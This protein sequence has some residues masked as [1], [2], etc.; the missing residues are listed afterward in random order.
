MGRYH[1]V[2]CDKCDGRGK[3][4]MTGEQILKTDMRGNKKGEPLLWWPDCKACNGKGCHIT[5]NPT[6]AT[7]SLPGKRGA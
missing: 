1:E 5:E 6:A 2:E 4:P 3:I 7:S